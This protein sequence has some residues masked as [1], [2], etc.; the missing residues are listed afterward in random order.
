[1]CTVG[2]AWGWA[3]GG[4]MSVCHLPG[5]KLKPT[6]GA[7]G[8]IWGSHLEQERGLDVPQ[9]PREYLFIYIPP[10]V[11]SSPRTRAVCH[12][13]SSPLSQHYPQRTTHRGGYTAR[14]CMLC[15]HSLPLPRPSRPTCCPDDGHQCPWP[16]T[17]P[18]PSLIIYVP[19]T[20]RIYSWEVRVERFR[21]A[22][23]PRT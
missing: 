10:G 14:L 22:Q 12:S 23:E 13:S 1:M 7:A 8:G 2:Y 21:I 9:T 20:C 4:F 18:L 17:C 19:L 3:G 6:P 16:G 5:P 11:L 15:A